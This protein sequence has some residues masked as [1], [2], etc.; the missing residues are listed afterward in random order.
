MVKGGLSVGLPLITNS[1]RRDHVQDN[2]DVL[3]RLAEFSPGTGD[4]NKKYLDNLIREV[5]SPRC[6]WGD[7]AIWRLYAEIFSQI[8]KLSISG[9]AAEES[10]LREAAINYVN[11]NSDEGNNSNE[12]I[13]VRTKKGPLFVP[14]SKFLRLFHKEILPHLSIPISEGFIEALG[15]A[16]RKIR[17]VPSKNS[18]KD[19]EEHSLS[20]NSNASLDALVQYL[21]S[22]SPQEFSEGVKTE[23]LRITAWEKPYSAMFTSK[24]KEVIKKAVL[25][26]YIGYLPEREKERLKVS[27]VRGLGSGAVQRTEVVT[28]RGEK[29]TNTYQYVQDGM[30]ISVF[31][32]N[33]KRSRINT[34]GLL[35]VDGLSAII[36]VI[37]DC[38]SG[39]GESLKYAK[40]RRTLKAVSALSNVLNEKGYTT[41]AD[42]TAGFLYVM[43]SDESYKRNVF[44]S[45]EEVGGKIVPFPLVYEEMRRLW[46]ETIAAVF[47][48]IQ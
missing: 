7:G 34:S 15:V 4:V 37:C 48:S 46:I 2:L 39:I 13:P 1:Q 36:Q 17:L 27:V 41:S 10:V 19:F 23:I 5:I 20:F 33:D 3:L 28:A 26:F 12:G 6:E 31:V 32:N 44:P 24:A 9:R 42:T 30:N 45:L 25:A 40:L 22:V 11:N 38:T 16:E 8:V 18:K 14:P 43:P 29:K 47:P 35:V 21:C